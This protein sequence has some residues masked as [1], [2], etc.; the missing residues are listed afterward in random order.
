MFFRIVSA[1]SCLVASMAASVEGDEFPV[2][3]K[4]DKKYASI[5]DTVEFNSWI[6]FPRNFKI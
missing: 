2:F 6:F 5:D 4:V 1:A 3:V